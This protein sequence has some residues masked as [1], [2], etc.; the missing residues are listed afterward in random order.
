MS[1]SE[2]GDTVYCSICETSLGQ[3][4]YFIA[5]DDVNF[6]L[7]DRCHDHGFFDGHETFSAKLINQVSF[8]LN[9][10]IKSL[11]PKQFRT[12]TP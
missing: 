7:C 3:E 10:F 4:V 8:L 5:D 1:V 11:D 12:I 6:V 2:I 9:C